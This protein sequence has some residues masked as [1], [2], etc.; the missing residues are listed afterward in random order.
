MTEKKAVYSKPSSQL[1]LEAR[2]KNGNES[3]A[4]LSTSEYF[5]GEAA[6]EGKAGYIGVDPQYQN[7]ANHTEA[8]GV[9]SKS[10]EDEIAAEFAGVD[11][12][13]VTPE[14]DGDDAQDAEDAKKSTG[15]TPRLS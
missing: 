4:V 2:L 15:T 9:S 11:L 8:P 5:K 7:H 6:P 14:Q 1:D 3:N 10:K 13:D 12:E